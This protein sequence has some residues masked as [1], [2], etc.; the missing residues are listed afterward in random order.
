[1]GLAISFVGTWVNK[2]WSLGLELLENQARIILCFENFLS[3][4]SCRGVGSVAFGFARIWYIN[5][6]LEH[7]VSQLVMGTREHEEHHSPLP[8]SLL[9]S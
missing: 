4:H 8:F 6:M 7:A 3:F 9:Q 5:C 2:P 1:M